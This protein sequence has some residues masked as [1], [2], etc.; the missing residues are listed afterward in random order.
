VTDGDAILRSLALLS[1]NR[2]DA[3]RIIKAWKDDYN[4]QRPH[5]SLGG[6]TPAEFADKVKAGLTL[7][8]A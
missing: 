5:S 7:S 3:A 6:L 8:V 1:R 2:L 4:H